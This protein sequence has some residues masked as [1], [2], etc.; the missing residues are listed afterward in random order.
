MKRRLARALAPPLLLVLP[1]LLAV[2]SPGAAQEAK[3]AALQDFSF[4]TGRWV[5]EA[6]GARIEEWWM[7][8]DGGALLGMFRVVAD[9][10]PI[11]YE[12]LVVEARPDGASLLLKHFGPD[13]SGR[14]AQGAAEPWTLVSLVGKKATWEQPGTGTTLSYERAAPDRLVAV[15]EKT[16]DGKRTREEYAYRSAP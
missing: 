12:L 8:P 9:G 4:L 5:G 11:L 1:L 15:L 6:G 16:K 3:R 2:A 14:E 7:G 13:L 10:K